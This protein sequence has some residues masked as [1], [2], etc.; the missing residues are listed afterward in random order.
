MILG[1]QSSDR[2]N[3][4]DA[5]SPLWDLLLGISKILL[6]KAAFYRDGTGGTP[7]LLRDGTPLQVPQRGE[8]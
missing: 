3:P 4:T 7:N 8:M 1:P 2:F 6:G 5:T